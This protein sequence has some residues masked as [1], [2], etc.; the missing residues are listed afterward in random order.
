MKSFRRI[1]A[2]LLVLCLAACSGNGGNKEQEKAFEPTLDKETSC[3]I[4]VVGHY[5]NFEALEEEFNRFNQFYP[6][7]EM[8]YRFLD[9]YKGIITTAL[10]SEEAP[11]IF[12]T[13]PSMINSP[14]FNEMFAH[15]ENLADES[16]GINLSIIRDSILYK[17]PQG[18]VPMVPV[19]ITTYGMMVNEDIFEKEKIAI[20]ETYDQ[21]VSACEALK[22]AGYESPMMGYNKAS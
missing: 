2:L 19:Y 12:F 9:N 17:D 21:L 18:N 7:V 1:I 20:P 15:A 16:L 10:T 3:S 4:V 5:N 11:D 14:D 8:E 22:K 6:N 13:Y